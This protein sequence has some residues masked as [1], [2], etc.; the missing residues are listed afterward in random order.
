MFQKIS[1]EKIEALKNFPWPNSETTLRRFIGMLLKKEK[2]FTWSEPQEKSFKKLKEEMITAPV[3]VH[4]DKQEDETIRPVSY[5][6]RKLIVAEMNYSTTDK[7]EL[8]VVY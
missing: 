7:K 3:I 5:V 2:I 4:P 1:Q 8:E 6:S